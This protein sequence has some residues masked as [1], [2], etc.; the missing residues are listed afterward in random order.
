MA[1]YI[2]STERRKARV[3]RALRAAANGRA[4]L[5]VHRSSKQIYA[6]IIDD[7]H[8]RTLAQASSLEKDLREKL[9]TGADI[10]A[11]KVVGKLIA[12]RAIAA[13][14]KEVVFDR[15][16]FIYHGR[17]KALADAAREGGLDF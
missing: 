17:I 5:S 11:A 10:E 16:A 2:S 4:R 12:E 9:K 3:R 15:G 8:G 7:T 1:E 14:V 13:G 6:Q